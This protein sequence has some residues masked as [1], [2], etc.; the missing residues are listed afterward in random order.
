MN[1]TS[2]M[3]NVCISL[4][5]DIYK[6]KVQTIFSLTVCQIC[7]TFYEFFFKNPFTGCCKIWHI[8]VDKYFHSRFA[9]KLLGSEGKHFLVGSVDFHLNQ[10][11]QWFVKFLTESI[12]F[13]LNWSYLEI[14]RTPCFYLG[15]ALDRY[16]NSLTGEYIR[17]AASIFLNP[18][19]KWKFEKLMRSLSG[20][21]AFLQ[22]IHN[23]I[24]RSAKLLQF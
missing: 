15:G 12:N 8:Q 19:L 10:R 13:Y 24:S 23:W 21:S 4:K 18:L 16:A 3:Y 5:V 9:A 11:L 17:S 20:P 6:I 14:Y 22:V 7:W 2:D 1:A